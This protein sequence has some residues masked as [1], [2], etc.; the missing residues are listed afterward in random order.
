MCI[1][2]CICIHICIHI[3]I[4]IH[5]GQVALAQRAARADASSAGVARQATGAPHTDRQDVRGHGWRN[6]RGFRSHYERPPQ[7]RHAPLD[8]HHLSERQRRPHHTRGMHTHAYTHHTRGMHVH[9]HVH[10]SYRRPHHTR[11]MHT[12]AYTH[13]RIHMHTCIHA[14]THTCI[15]AYM[16][17]RIIPAVCN[18]GLR[19]GKGSPHLLTYLLTYLLT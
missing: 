3:H 15:H 2:I 17:T 10:V 1:W 16:H 5:G 14:Y 6:G 18:G 12:H 9:V 8:A 4:H 13:T 7:G 11:A 19:G